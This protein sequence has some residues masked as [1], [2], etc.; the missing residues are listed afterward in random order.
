MK[1]IFLAKKFSLPTL[2]TV[3]YSSGYLLFI[4]YLT[5]CFW[6]DLLHLY[7][8]TKI[9]VLDSREITS[10]PETKKMWWT[11][12]V[13]SVIAKNKQH[14]QHQTH[15]HVQWKFTTPNQLASP[16]APLIDVLL[17]IN[18]LFFSTSEVFTC[19]QHLEFVD[20]PIP[21]KL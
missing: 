10:L 15:L 14:T 8:Y 19:N 12:H 5:I 3:E 4:W 6:I 18:I 13:I 1:Q 20:Q 11:W 17:I 2:S 9:K 16:S 7:K 21:E